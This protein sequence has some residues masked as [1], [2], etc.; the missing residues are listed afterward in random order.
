M[1]Q[2]EKP[3]A[4]GVKKILAG[5]MRDWPELVGFHNNKSPH[6]AMAGGIIE[7]SQ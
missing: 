6:Q 1:K 5:K 2:Y 3:A 7:S 4:Q